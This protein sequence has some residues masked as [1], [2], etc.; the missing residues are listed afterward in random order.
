MAKSLQR[1]AW[2][3]TTRLLYF[4]HRG[5]LAKVLVDLRSKYEN[6]VDNVS[7]RI[8]LAFVEKVIKKF[9]KEQKVNDPYVA[10]W[11][12]EYIFMGTKQREVNLDADDTELEQFKF[13]YRSACCDAFAQPHTHNDN[14]DITFVCLKCEKV[15]SAYRVPNLD[16]FE[17]KRKLRAEKRK[18]EEQI[19]K[20]VDVLG[21]G[22]EKAPLI[23]ETNY[24]VVLGEGQKKKQVKNLA[25]ADQRAIEDINQLSPMDREVVR[26]KLRQRLDMIIDGEGQEKTE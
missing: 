5:D 23:K 1:L 2:E 10:T 26:G 12:L 25:G 18:D 3:N 19:V 9:K 20:A 13:S 11:V 24:Q 7:D 16:I 6:E 21:F 4:K 8:T 22:G 17:M 15:C 14:D